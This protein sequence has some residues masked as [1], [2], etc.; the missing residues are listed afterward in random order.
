RAADQSGRRFVG[1]L[2]QDRLRPEAAQLAREPGRQRQVE[3]RA[4]QRLGPERGDEREDRVLRRTACDRR[5][6]DAEVED[7]LQRAELPPE[8]RI[9]RDD[10]AGAPGAED[11]RLQP[12]APSR[13]ASSRAYTRSGAYFATDGA[14]S[15]RRR[16]RRPSSS[17]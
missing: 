12:A 4:V 8:A 7:V 3:E 14:A 11:A 15:S 1:T 5:P 10:V 2:G 17:K 9:E 16:A 13:T 6:D